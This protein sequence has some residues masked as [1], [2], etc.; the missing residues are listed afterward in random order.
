VSKSPKPRLSLEVIADDRDDLAGVEGLAQE[1]VI[2]REVDHGGIRGKPGCLHLADQVRAHDG[3]VRPVKRGDDSELVVQQPLGPGDEYPG[4][5]FRRAVLHL[6]QR[7]V[8]MF[9]EMHP[10]TDPRKQPRKLM[11]DAR[12]FVPAP[13]CYEDEFA[14]MAYRTK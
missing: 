9:D 2:V 12:R 4:L 5:D 1:A 11:P 10:V 7:T 13:V 14:D 8:G 6:S 3:F